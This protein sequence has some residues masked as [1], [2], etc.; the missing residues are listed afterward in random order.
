MKNNVPTGAT[1]ATA[2]E[3]EEHRGGESGLG[4]ATLA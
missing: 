1:T 3:L 2:R 4:A